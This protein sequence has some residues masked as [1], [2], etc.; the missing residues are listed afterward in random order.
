MISDDIEEAFALHATETALLAGTMFLAYGLGQIPA[1]ALLTRFGPRTVL[2]VAGALLALSFWFFAEAESFLELLAARLAM[3]FAAAPMLAGS[4]AVYTGFGEARFTTL[5]GLQTAFG[6]AG[7]IIA[8]TPL[9]LLV[10]AVGWRSALLW[11]AVATG[12]AAVAATAVLFTAERPVSAAPAAEAAASAMKGLVSSSAFRIAA[13]FQG[14]ATAVGSTI[15]G[16]WGGPW[17]SDVYGMEM[18]EQ[19]AM[20]LALAL[21][22]FVSAPL[23]GQL[24]RHRASHGLVQGAAAVAVLL[25]ALPALVHLP[26]LMILP[27]LV[28]LGLATGFYPAVLNALRRDLPGDSIVALSTLLTAGTMLVVFAVQFATGVLAD[29]FPGR[30]AGRAP[31]NRLC[32]DLPADGRPPRHRNLWL[33]PD[34][35]SCGR[36]GAGADKNQAGRR[37]SAVSPRRYAGIRINPC[38][39]RPLRRAPPSH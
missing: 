16:L 17:L 1:A 35:E 26:R 4:Y 31:G 12:A 29:Q 5:T 34:R 6:R 10:A 21:A 18:R 2:P 36:R 19:G 13:L 24:A 38:E 9:A 39:S 23:W 27:W 25:L 7:V 22:A 11:A 14:V 32:R 15:L 33:L 8:T 37:P 28:G 30:P 20:L 3:G